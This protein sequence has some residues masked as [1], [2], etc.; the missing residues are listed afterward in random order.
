MADPDPIVIKILIA[1]LRDI[2]KDTRR[3]AVMKLGMQGGDQAVRALIDVV[4]NPYEDLIVRGKAAQ[5]LGVMGDGRAVDS[6]I[7]A[8]EAPGYQTQLYA[9]EALGKLGNQRA[10]TSLVKVANDRTRDRVRVAAQTA[11]KLL[12]HPDGDADPLPSDRDTRML[13]EI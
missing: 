7:K 4:G 8:L 6:L 1:E 11:L 13:E 5:M 3:S 9:A 10:V 12:G 2:N